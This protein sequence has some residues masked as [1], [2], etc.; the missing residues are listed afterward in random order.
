MFV[1][2]LS[3][4][5]V[6]AFTAASLVIALPVGLI[7]CCLAATLRGAALSTRTPM[8]W[9]LGFIVLL[10]L[11]G[12]SGVL[13]SAPDAMIARFHF[14]LALSAVFAIFAGFYFWIGRMTGRPYPEALGRL[15]FCVTFVGVNLAFLPRLFP[16]A[17]SGW[18]TVATAGGLLSG[19]SMLLFLLVA[20]VTLSRKP[21]PG[22]TQCGEGAD[23]R[24]WSV[25]PPARQAAS[26]KTLRLG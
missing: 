21:G 16:G 22:W 14:T 13:A 23:M 1:A 2:G 12:A 26:L 20:A 24:D 19:A 5:S 17:A 7:L 4:G 11:G 6:G 18:S 25:P 15:H 9:A 3:G 10:A 8:L